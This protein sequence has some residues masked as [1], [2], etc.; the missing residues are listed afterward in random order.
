[1]RRESWNSRSHRLFKLSTSSSVTWPPNTTFLIPSDGWNST[2]YP[3]FKKIKTQKKKIKFFSISHQPHK[4]KRLKTKRGV[5]CG[6]FT[7]LVRTRCR[8]SRS[9]WIRRWSFGPSEQIC[10]W[11]VR[12]PHRSAPLH[13]PEAGNSNS[14]WNQ[15]TL[16]NKK[17]QKLQREKKH[18]EG[19]C[20][21][22]DERGCCCR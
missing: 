13:F 6:R 17:Q 22:L 11:S 10:G 2:E 15:S 21:I 12:F 16:M 4:E 7:Y 14:L 3:Q 18:G 20:L 8:G 19:P 1:M 5:Y 9:W